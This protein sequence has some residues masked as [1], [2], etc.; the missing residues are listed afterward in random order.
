M[1]A[2]LAMK[3]NWESGVRKPFAFNLC[4]P[5]IFLVSDSSQTKYRNSTS[6]L[7][8]CCILLQLMARLA[9]VSTTIALSP[10]VTRRIWTTFYNSPLKTL[11]NL[12][13][14]PS[15]FLLNHTPRI[16]TVMPIKPIPRVINFGHQR[17]RHIKVHKPLLQSLR[18]S[19]ELRHVL[20]PL[21]HL[22]PF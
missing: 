5:F 11:S 16:T 3:A 18:D 15:S 9:S 19:C 7:V 14:T 12:F 6:S 17:R 1:E 22:R 10:P 2:A 4:M 13:T 8:S 20:T 21:K